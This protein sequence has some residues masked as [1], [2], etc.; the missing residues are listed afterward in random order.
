MIKT[1]NRLGK[2][3][4]NND[5]ENLVIINYKNSLN[6]DVKFDD[7]TIVLNK[8]YDNINKGII[9]NPNYKNHIN[10]NIR[11]IY[12]IGFIGG[13]KYNNKNFSFSIWKEMIRRCYSEKF[14]LINKTYI[15]CSVDEKWHNFQNF[16]EWFYSEKSGYLEGYVLDKDIL[17]KGNKIYGP[18]TC[19]FVPSQI[20]SLFTKRIKTDKIDNLPVGV[21]NSKTNKK[22]VAT[23]RKFHRN[24]YLGSFDTIEEAEEVYLAERK[25]FL[26][27]V[28]NK[29]KDKIPE[30]VYNLIITYED[31]LNGNI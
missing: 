17:I 26:K 8:K 19:C 5:G 13:D 12:N 29:W 31:A 6:V 18:D 21:Q 3:Y 22:Y 23:I 11:T 14:L 24:I 16:S 15:G 4:I 1:E 28:A 20:N 25:I 2:K 9:R 27:D 7:G 10:K 30:K